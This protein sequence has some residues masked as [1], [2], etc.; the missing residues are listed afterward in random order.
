MIVGRVVVGRIGMARW[1]SVGRK[2]GRVGSGAVAVAVGL[3]VL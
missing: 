3:L 2:G 1:P